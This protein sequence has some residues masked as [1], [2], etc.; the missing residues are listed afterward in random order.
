M[1]QSYGVTRSFYVPSAE[2]R[3][4]EAESYAVTP[5]ARTDIIALSFM[6]PKPNKVFL[7]GLTTGLLIDTR[8]CTGF[9]ICAG[10]YHQ[11]VMVISNRK[12]ADVLMGT[13]MG[14]C[15]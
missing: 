6:H 14:N 7:N 9:W 13:A 1:P 12:A 11:L 8:C 10:G 3:G 5:S 2:F 15:D 4:A